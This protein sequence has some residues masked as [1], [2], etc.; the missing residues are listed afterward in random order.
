[1]NQ[2]TDSL[3]E[4]LLAGKTYSLERT[5]SVRKNKGAFPNENS[6]LKFLYMGI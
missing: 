2:F 5:Q 1:L 3:D 4:I 6:L